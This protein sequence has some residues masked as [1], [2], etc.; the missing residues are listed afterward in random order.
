LLSGRQ[1]TAKRCHRQ[2]IALPERMVSSVDKQAGA[3][4]AAVCENYA[5][6]GNTPVRASIFRVVRA[7]MGDTFRVSPIALFVHIRS[8]TD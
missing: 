5:A 2:G 6:D 8:R 4:G 3:V 1:A 7:V